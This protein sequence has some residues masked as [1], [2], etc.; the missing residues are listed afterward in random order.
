MPIQ[1]RLQVHFVLP[2]I[3]PE[4]RLMVAVSSF[5]I[6][7]EFNFVVPFLCFSKIFEGALLF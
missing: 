2:G 4:M 6:D 7:S 1:E 5:L 3:N